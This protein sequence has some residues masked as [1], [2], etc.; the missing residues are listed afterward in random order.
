MEYTGPHDKAFNNFTLLFLSHEVPKFHN[1]IPWPFHWYV[2]DSIL[3]LLIIFPNLFYYLKESVSVGVL[4][5]S[6]AQLND[7]AQ[8][9]IPVV[10]SHLKHWPFHAQQVELLFSIF[11]LPKMAIS[12]S[13]KTNKQKMWNASLKTIS[14]RTRHG[15]HTKSPLSHCSPEHRDAHINTKTDDACQMTWIASFGCLGLP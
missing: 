9:A 2:A 3:M 10:K 12:T 7:K 1:L 15:F 14:M 8:R 5:L 11:Y 4:S 6:P 13:I